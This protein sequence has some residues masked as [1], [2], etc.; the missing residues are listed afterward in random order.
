MRSQPGWVLS[1]VTIQNLYLYYIYTVTIF[2]SIIHSIF[3]W[4]DNLNMILFN[5][6]FFLSSTLGSFTNLHR[7]YFFSTLGSF[8]NLHHFYFIM[9]TGKHTHWHTNACIHKLLWQVILVAALM[10]HIDSSQNK[11]N[12]THLD[13]AVPSLHLEKERK[14]YFQLIVLHH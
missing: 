6:N 10:T 13:S 7:F 9:H 4:Q 14:M 5:L 3:L 2:G 8:T 1:K 12:V 11:T